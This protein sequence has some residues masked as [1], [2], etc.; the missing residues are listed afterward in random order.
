MKKRH[1]L[2]GVALGT[3][4]LITG[5][6]S[7]DLAARI[8]EKSAVYATLK[9]WQKRQIDQ[10]IIATGFTPNM[11]YMAI[12]NPSMKQPLT[13]DGELWTYR[14]YYP[15]VA[16]N[17]VRYRMTTEAPY[18]YS[19]NLRPGMPGSNA[20]AGRRA[21]QLISIA[22]TGGPQGGSM[23]PAEMTSYTLWLMFEKGEVTKMK[24]A[25]NL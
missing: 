19:G 24:L 25:Q 13:N 5:C 6:E 16:A 22:Q 17:R 7:D 9:P 8:Q 4:L 15:S 10:G 12:G 2:L 1:S 21:G 11:V 3:A 20:P 14:N 23:E 18:A